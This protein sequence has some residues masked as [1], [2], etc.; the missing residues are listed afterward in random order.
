MDIQ[1]VQKIRS[2]VRRAY[3]KAAERPDDDH[4]F[5]V[6]RDFA[7]G[8]GYPDE[9]LSEIPSNSVDAFTGVSNVAIFADIPKGSTVLDLGCG[10]GLDTEVK[11]VTFLKADAEDLP[12]QSGS[13]NVA[14]VNGIFNLNPSRDAIFRELARLVRSDGIVYAA[15]LI[16]K[17]GLPEETQTCEANWFA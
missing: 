5:P 6:G 1:G 15:E 7:L 8:I 10:G 4:P 12:I 17:E 3:S 13:I 11:N 16:L 14:M 2:G 9:V